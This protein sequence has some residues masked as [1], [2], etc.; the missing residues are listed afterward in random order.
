[1]MDL[2]S[3][4]NPDAG[5]AYGDTNRHQARADFQ[6]TSNAIAAK[7][8][9][10]RY[11]KAASTRTDGRQDRCRKHRE[12]LRGAYACSPVSESYWSS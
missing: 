9:G 4:P 8:A 6:E 7:A 1:M 3:A 10:C 12:E 5:K 11:C 2:L